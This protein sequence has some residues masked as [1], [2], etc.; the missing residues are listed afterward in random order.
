MILNTLSIRTLGILGILSGATGFF[1]LIFP[2]YYS[3]GREAYIPKRNP[4]FGYFLPKT[5]GAWL[6]LILA[7]AMLVFSMVVLGFYLQ[8]KKSER[9]Y[10]SHPTRQIK[11]SSPTLVGGVS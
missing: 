10:N 2:Y 11:T 5:L 3:P 6:F 9:K 4:D 1:L 7:L 8:R